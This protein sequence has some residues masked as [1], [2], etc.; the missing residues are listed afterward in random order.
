MCSLTLCWRTD[1]A[2]KGTV[3]SFLLSCPSLKTCRDSFKEFRASILTT[4]PDLLSLVTEC[5][6]TD[7]VQFWLDC[8][9][10]PQVILAVQQWGLRVLYVLFKLSR[11][12]CH[13]L[14]KERILLLT[15]Q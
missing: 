13:N 12:Y 11:H 3:E 10:M 5:L 15:D 9:T 6:E 7:P 2:H 1:E 8:S 4:R 14:H